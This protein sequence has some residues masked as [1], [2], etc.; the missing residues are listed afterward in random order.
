MYVNLVFIRV[1]SKKYQLNDS[2]TMNQNSQRRHDDSQ[3]YKQ[4]DVL[5]EAEKRTIMVSYVDRGVI[6]SAARIIP[7]PERNQIYVN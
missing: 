7:V 5:P 6:T 4:R 3:R 1:S 2:S